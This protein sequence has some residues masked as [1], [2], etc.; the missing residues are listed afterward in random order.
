MAKNIALISDAGTPLISD[1][2]YKLVKL[3]RENNIDVIPIPGPSAL[4]SA[5]SVSGLE[6]DKFLFL[7]FLPK[8]K[9]KRLKELESYKNFNGSIVIYISVHKIEEILNEIYEIF[10]NRKVFIAREMTKAFEEYIYGN[11]LDVKEKIK[12][13]GEFVLIISKST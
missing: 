13:K 9:N 4:I 6:T 2:G 11:L 8:K 3:C 1:P 5:L 12:K 10:G 7:G